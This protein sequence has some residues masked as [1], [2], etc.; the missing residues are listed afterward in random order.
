MT[1][2]AETEGVRELLPRPRC[3]REIVPVD[4]RSAIHSYPEGVVVPRRAFDAS[5]HVIRSTRCNTE[6]A[7]DV[8]GAIGRSARCAVVA[9][10]N[11][12]II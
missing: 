7:I 12:G 6:W 5:K 8:T 9:R 2:C 10:L 1:A 3:R 11:G 4:P